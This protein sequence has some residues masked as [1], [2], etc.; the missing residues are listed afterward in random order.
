MCS[1]LVPKVR[2]RTGLSLGLGKHTRNPFLEMRQEGGTPTS[3]PKRC[4]GIFTP[5]GTMGVVSQRDVVT[6]RQNKGWTTSPGGRG[7]LGLN[8]EHSIVRLFGTMG[9]GTS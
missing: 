6:R 3:K 5:H 2:R 9:F 7:L 4:V 1:R 8:L